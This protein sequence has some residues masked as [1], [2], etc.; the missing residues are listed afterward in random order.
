MLVNVVIIKRLLAETLLI[1]VGRKRGCIESI[2]DKDKDFL[3]G[4]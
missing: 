1:I 3:F 4:T 2:N